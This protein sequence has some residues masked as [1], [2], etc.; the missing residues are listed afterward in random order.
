MFFKEPKLRKKCEIE[1]YVY[2]I[3]KQKPI[4]IFAV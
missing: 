3:K 2:K 1:K 4:I